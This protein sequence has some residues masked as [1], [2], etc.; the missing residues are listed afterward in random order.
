MKTAAET[1]EAIIES[2][3]TIDLVATP[4]KGVLKFQKL[5]L[6][7]DVGYDA[8]LSMDENRT[9]SLWLKSIE[10]SVQK[11]TLWQSSGVKATILATDSGAD[12]SWVVVEADEIFSRDLFASLTQS[13]VRK[14][15][16]GTGETKA[17]V[18]AALDEWS[19]LFLK[20]KNGLDA[21]KLSGLIGELLTLRAQLRQPI[22]ERRLPRGQSEQGRDVGGGQPLAA[23]GQPLATQVGGGAG[24]GQDDGGG[25]GA[26]S[27]PHWH[28]WFPG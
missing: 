24:A 16:T 23:A 2:L 10:K 1:F 27:S 15:L 17:K 6:G 20:N 12:H 25:H 28:S 9:I 8:R 11:K 5:E 4:T 21:Q 18:C 13:I 22:V 7:H 3:E 19:E 14:Y 26:H